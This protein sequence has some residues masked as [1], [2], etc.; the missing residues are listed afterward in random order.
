[1]AEISHAFLTYC[2][3]RKVTCPKDK[4]K[5]YEFQTVMC[6]NAM[7]QAK[8]SVANI[9]KGNVRGGMK[10]KTPDLKAEGCSLGQGA[11]NTGGLAKPNLKPAP[12]GDLL[13]E[14]EKVKP[15]K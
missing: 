13:K 4:E 12:Q 11:E 10:V 8:E 15:K 2:S 1:M 9:L 14:A 6:L 7:N 5:V 3:D